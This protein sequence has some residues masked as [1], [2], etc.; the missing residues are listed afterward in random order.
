M[1]LSTTY[2]GLRLKNPLV[3]SASP[4]SRTVDGIRQLEDAGA[5][6]VV[7]F[8]LFEEQVTQEDRWAAS[9][10]ASKG[11]R[12]YLDALRYYP[13]SAQYR[14]GTDEYLDLV[15]LA[16]RS[17]GIP[18]IGSLNGVSAIG[19]TRYARLMEQAGADA[20]E[21]N[22]YYLPA[23]AALTGADV[24]KKYL[25]TVR[26]VRESVTC[27]VAVKIGPYFS[28][29]PNMVSRFV[30]VGANALVLFNRFYQPDFDVESEAT[31]AH[32]TLS[33]SEDLRAALR[34]VSLLSGNVGVDF[35]VTGGVH[36]HE[37][38]LKAVL[39]GARV[40]QMASELL[41]NGPNRLREIEADLE[42]W[43]DAHQFGALSELHGRRTLS[44][45]VADPVASERTGYIQM[46]HSLDPELS[47]GHAEEK[48][49]Q[50]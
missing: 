22:L 39:A 18:V 17:L 11:T 1:D 47:G 42:R 13:S 7:L 9:I 44:T 37:D 41:Q 38:V 34:W 3:A 45:L 40:T 31:V 33:R 2:L 26:A 36:T 23:D 48:E 24:E 10:D 6:A 21:L 12:G 20:V 43:L 19:W 15:S 16:K 46:L 35:A 25:D 28:A 8:S 50:R 27:P 49:K 29:L 5:A 30:E 14:V 4:L 32:I